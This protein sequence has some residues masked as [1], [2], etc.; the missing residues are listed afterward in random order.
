MSPVHRIINLCCSLSSCVV[1][2]AAQQPT[3]NLKFGVINVKGNTFYYREVAYMSTSSSRYRT[4]KK[5]LIMLA[6]QNELMY[7]HI[8]ADD[9]KEQW[10]S[11]QITQ[12]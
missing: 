6:S 8:F 4:G 9:K 7:K 5:W 11:D 2:A 3:S 10:R 1:F 12:I